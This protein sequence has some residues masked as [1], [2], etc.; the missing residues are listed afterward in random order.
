MPH[1]DASALPSPVDPQVETACA[2]LWLSLVKVPLLLLAFVPVLV[3]GSVFFPFMAPKSLGLRVLIALAF[4]LFSGLLVQHGPSRRWAASRF[5][6]Q[7]RKP[8]FLALL[9]VLASDALSTVLALDRYRAFWGTVER[10][11][12]FAFLALLFG[13]FFLTLVVFNRGDWVLFFELS[14]AAGAV[15]VAGEFVEWSTGTERPSSLAGNPIFL[16]AYLLFILFCAGVVLSEER[17]GPR[18]PPWRRVPALLWR[19]LA[20]GMVPAALLGIFVTE[21]R[22]VL[23]GLAAGVASAA[24]LVAWRKRDHLV[25]RSVTGRRLGLTILAALALFG[26]LFAVTRP[27]PVW[28]RVPGLNRLA[29]FGADAVRLYYWKVAFRAAGPGRWGWE[30]TAAGWG[31]ENVEFA[32]NA[33]AGPSYEALSVDWVDRTHNAFLDALVMTGLLGLV[34]H[35]ALWG[36]LAWLVIFRSRS[37]ALSALSLFFAASYLFQDMTAFTSL[38]TYVPLYAFFGFVAH[39]TGE[40]D[41]PE[42]RMKPATAGGS[43]PGLRW[44]LALA[45]LV[46][47]LSILYS[48]FAGY[49]LVGYRQMR[50]ASACLRALPSVPVKAQLDR[51]FYPV[52]YVQST[53]R[54]GC[55]NVLAPMVW[56]CPQLM[57]TA[58]SVAH[59]VEKLSAEDPSDARPRV[60]VGQAYVQWYPLTVNREQLRRGESNLREAVR[61]APGREDI[62]CILAYGLALD[63][64]TDEAFRILREAMAMAPSV[65]IPHYFYG[66]TVTSLNVTGRYGRALAQME[67]AANLKGP[68]FP[69][70]LRTKSIYESLMLH[71]ALE[72]DAERFALAANRLAELEPA[73]AR[74]LREEA[75]QVLKGRWPWPEEILRPVF[76]GY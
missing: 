18:D 22:G 67:I 41:E 23:L 14:L 39:H 32:F 4:I 54:S 31:P 33:N 73:R 57:P 7:A 64:R 55:L 49:A 60:L 51:A 72:R 75:G 36:C 65:Y 27:S 43:P 34:L 42:A 1:G 11:G 17:A 10:D 61:L 13:L 28:R 9:A 24:A 74:A 30:R 37:F 29:E 8:L 45:G 53:I 56:P 58:V 76:R 16:G 6:E 15:L 59:A 40:T 35:L 2:G 50:T 26:A 62:R 66:F 20:L 70:D 12:G 47:L 25:L 71:F 48:I 68:D 5:K 19:L 3:D 63:G 44:S 21:S 69:K 52:T 38:V 46:A